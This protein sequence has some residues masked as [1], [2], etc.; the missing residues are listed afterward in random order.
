MLS[1]CFLVTFRIR[2][3]VGER[4]FGEMDGQG[5]EKKGKSW[6]GYAVGG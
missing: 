5:D 6:S 3:G 2:L 1:C 4:V